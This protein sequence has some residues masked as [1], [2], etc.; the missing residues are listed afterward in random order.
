[1]HGAFSEVDVGKVGGLLNWQR[2]Q[3]DRVNQLKNRGIRPDT[4][5]QRQNGYKGKSRVQA[6]LPEPEA[7]ILNDGRHR[8]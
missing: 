4:Q 7:Q 6:E 3:P 2:L 1:M 5:R 8:S